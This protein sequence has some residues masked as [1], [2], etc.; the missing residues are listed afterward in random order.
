MFTINDD[1]S[2]HA[3]RGDTV[4]FTVTAEENGTPYFFE[5]GDVLRMKIFGKKNAQDVVLEKCFPVTARTDRFTILLT[6][7]DTKIGEVISKPKDY[8]Y[9]IEL[10][11][12]TNPQTIIG[13]DEDGAK[14]FKLF[15]EGKDSEVPEVDPEDIPVV[16]IELD[17]TSH[18]PVQNQAISRAI[19]NLEA[20][21]QVTKKEVAEAAE[22][23]AAIVANMGVEL[24]SSV[25]KLDGKIATE[26]TRIDNLASGSTADGAE[27]ADIR[28]GADGKTYA[29][30]GTAVREQFASLTEEVSLSKGAYCVSP[31]FAFG[32]R[33]IDE[34]GLVH[35]DQN[36]AV[37]RAM[38]L[39]D[40][41]GIKFRLYQYNN[42][43]DNRHLAMIAYYDQNLQH[44]HSV[45]HIAEANGIV[46]ASVIPPEYAKYAIV[47]LYKPIGN[48][49]V[50]FYYS[51]DSIAHGDT[52]HKV[53]NLCECDTETGYIRTDGAVVAD[54]NWV[55][56]DYIAV[57]PGET[58]EL[59][60]H[61]HVAVNSVSYYNANKSLISGLVADIEYI[62]GATEKFRYGV[63]TIPDGVAYL[64]LC[65]RINA[66]TV[67]CCKYSVNP[68]DSRDAEN[69]RKNTEAIQ[70]LTK[71][72][73]AIGQQTE[74]FL[75]GKT[76]FLAGDSRS[77]TDY[78]FYGETMEE[79][80][81]ATVIVGGAS[82]WKTSAIA[83]NSYFSRL[84]NNAHDFSL[85]LVGGNDTGEKGTVGTF[86]ANSENG[87]DGESVVSETDIT[88]DY[89][90][91]TFVQAVDHI[92]RKYKALF[93]DWKKL[94]NGHKPKMI[95]CTDI[96]QKRSG[97]ENTWSLSANWERKR[98]AIIECC[99]KNNVSCLDLY[100]LCNFDMDFEP[101][102]TSP[103]DM[104]NNNGLYFMDGLHPNKYG[105]DII[106]SLEIEE[107]RKYLTIH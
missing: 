40:C 39:T 6:E 95:F 13:Y 90:G 15:P 81:G 27:V 75:A 92:M 86:A 69:I 91:T 85:W 94:N 70:T 55:Y 107:I 43:V 62:I 51:V 84:T 63:E 16:D 59:S 101:E 89:N 50:E 48:G 100:G 30:A 93:Y 96:P 106:T 56:T 105:I 45:T 4:F 18:R 8:W 11:P 34:N 80:S 38:D 1:L 29:S 2:I 21:Y 10:N 76:V 57:N 22:E 82:G 97:G 23:T 99:K 64:R 5:A 49:Y 65:Y 71:Q 88:K 33:W 83:S 26:R 3:T 54:E 98:N 103:T 17:M 52:I 58:I 14:V 68:F 41:T 78:D 31:P 53:V 102:W 32:Y 35:E 73:S 25:A 7:E 47:S 77:S 19:V 20:A 60:M 87:L 66:N 79:K 61:G 67:S 37:T 74:K 46:E 72:V 36:Y 9:E 28:V 44:I 12:F 104:V 42:D 24:D